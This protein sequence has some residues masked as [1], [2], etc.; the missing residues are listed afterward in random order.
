LKEI[1]EWLRCRGQK[2]FRYQRQA[3]R[4]YLRGESGL[5]HAPTGF[6]KTLAAWLGPVAEWIGERSGFEEDEGRAPQPGKRRGRTVKRES[7]E[8]LRVLWNT[9]LRALA[10]D[11]VQALQEPIA[12]LGL[13]W[14]VELRLPPRQAGSSIMPSKVNPVIPEAVS[15]A[16]LAVMAHD[17]AVTQACALGN[18]ELN[19]FLPLVADALLDSLDLLAR[20]ATILRTHCVDGLAADPERLRQHVDTSTATLTAL[21]AQI[22]YQPATE[23]AAAAEREH[24]TIR[25]LVL[26][27]GLLTADAFD[28][29][30]AP[31]AVL[32]LGLPEEAGP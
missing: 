10:N 3:W 26:E 15:Q 13:P 30:I 29:L 8:P 23:L 17:Q 31:E 7:Y 32:R 12:G 22:G 1:V 2:P 28:R 24:K 4:A 5:I 20:A 16:A 6:G 18:L 11:T 9:P 19:A 21:V 27:R 25:A 14:L